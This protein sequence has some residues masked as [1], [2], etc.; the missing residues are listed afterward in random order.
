MVVEYSPLVGMSQSD[1]PLVLI[2]QPKS[3]FR[4]RYLSEVYGDRRRARRYIRAISS[5]GN[6]Q[7]QYPTIEVNKYMSLCSVVILHLDS[8]RMEKTTGLHSC[9]ISDGFK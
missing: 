3:S 7:Y 8:T 2:A 5:D 6:H 1:S 4:E 9:N